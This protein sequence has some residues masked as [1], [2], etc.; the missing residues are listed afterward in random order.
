MCSLPPNDGNIR[1]VFD[2]LVE[3]GKVDAGE[4]ANLVSA[5][6]TREQPPKAEG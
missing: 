2:Y 6:S 1:I 5:M 3:C 4:T